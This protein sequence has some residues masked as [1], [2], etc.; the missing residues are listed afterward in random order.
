MGY[1][2]LGKFVIPKDLD[3][4]VLIKDLNKVVQEMYGQDDSIAHYARALL[5]V[6]KIHGVGE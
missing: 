5:A 4:E 3:I 6:L 2:K 1:D